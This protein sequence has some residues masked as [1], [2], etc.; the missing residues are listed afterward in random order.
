MKPHS[1]RKFV[2]NF[3]VDFEFNEIEGYYEN[4][5]KPSE[6][7]F[8]EYPKVFIQTKDKNVTQGFIY[9]KDKKPIAIPEP[10]PSILYFTNAE[11][12]LIHLLDFQ[13]KIIESK[14]FD[15]FNELSHTFFEFFQMSSDF[16]INLF[17]SIEAFNNSLIPDDFN[18]KI[19]RKTFDK[20]QA[21]KSIDFLTK[22]KKV[23]PSIEKKSYFKDYPKDYDFLLK[24]KKLRDNV[25]HTKN[26]QSGFPASYRELYVSYI[27]FDF[28]KSYEL[29]KNYM[30]YY[31]DNWI[32][33]C[34]CGI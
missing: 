1:K 31:K 14:Q 29:V 25:V 5:K 18:I 21:Q 33:N 24:F 8:E 17:T 23:V 6:I 30:N 3:K 4:A 7:D 32:E 34:N 20:F 10:E 26:L 11:N 13:K 9:L 15:N 2:G 16:I 27:D 28:E 19:K 12:K 22:V